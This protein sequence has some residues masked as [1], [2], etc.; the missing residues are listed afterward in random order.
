MELYINPDNGKLYALYS[1]NEE[2]LQ[3]F[4]SIERNDVKFDKDINN[5]GVI[6]TKNLTDANLKLLTFDDLVFEFYSKDD[7]YME[8]AS[9][10]DGKEVSRLSDIWWY[11]LVFKSR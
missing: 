10:N 6:K 2:G 5:S 1:I 8:E 7:E 9:P 4:V 3:T 11:R